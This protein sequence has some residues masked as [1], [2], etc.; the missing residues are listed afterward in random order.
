MTFTKPLIVYSG[1]I[2]GVRMFEARFNLGVF[3]FHNISETNRPNHKADFRPHE[4]FD[5]IPETQL[6][7]LAWIENAFQTHGGLNRGSFN[8]KLLV[9]THRRNNPA[10]IG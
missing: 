2:Q 4:I 9:S 6:I 10:R 7:I 8:R 5:K 3:Y 1:E